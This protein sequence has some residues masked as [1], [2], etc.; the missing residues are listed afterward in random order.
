[1]FK[2]SI[3]FTIVVCLWSLNYSFGQ[4]WIRKYGGGAWDAGARWVIEDNDRGFIILGDAKNYKYGWIIKTDINGYVIWNKKLGNGNYLEIPMNIEKARTNGYIISGTTG[5]LDYKND[6]FIMRMNSC[7]EIQWCKVI[8]TPNHSDFGQRIRQLPDKGY[9]FLS[10]YHSA[11]ISSRISLIRF[12]SIGNMLWLQD[13]KP[14]DTLTFNEDGMDVLITGTNNYLITGFCYHTDSLPNGGGWIHPYFIKTDS[15]GDVIWELPYGVQNTFYGDAFNSVENFSGNIFSA[16]R[17]TIPTYG[18][19]PSMIKTSSNG[20]ELYHKDLVAN[21]RGGLATT[22][23]WLNSTKLVLAASWTT[24]GFIGPTGIFKIDTLGNIVAQKTFMNLTNTISS[25]AKTVDDKFISIGSNATNGV[26]QIYAFKVNSDMQYDTI[27]THQFTY[28]S[29]CPHPIVSDTVDPDC[30]VIVSIE[31]PDL[32]PEKSQLQVFPNPATKQLHVLLPLQLVERSK[33]QSFFVTTVHQ[34][35][36][37]TS[38]EVY[39]MSSVRIYQKNIS[40][41]QTR[42]EIDVSSWPKGMYFFRLVY[43]KQTVAGEK[44][45]IE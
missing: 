12:D 33:T 44:V 42:L 20:T 43:N 21:T 7:M 36:K 15:L 39:N 11:N 37:E 28:D 30:D 4:E 13:Y 24:T 45:I 14:V 35:W 17:H 18:D 6:P 9:I 34:Q 27:Y 3:W 31:D 5:K 40:K 38:L 2:K 10:R 22:I 1:M 19:A 41:D 23:T 16:S 25:T 8:S 32:H 29:L 26:F